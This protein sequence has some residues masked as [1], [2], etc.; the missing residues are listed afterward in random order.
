MLGETW[1]WEKQRAW[2]GG[3]LGLAPMRPLSPHGH[4]VGA[5]AAAPLLCRAGCCNQPELLP[6]EPRPGNALGTS[7]RGGS[8]FKTRLGPGHG[9]KVSGERAAPA[10]T[11]SAAKG[12]DRRTKRDPQ[13]GP[14][15]A[16]SPGRENR[17]LLPWGGT[18]N[19]DPCWDV[20]P[21]VGWKSPEP[22]GSSARVGLEWRGWRAWQGGLVGGWTPRRGIFPPD[23][24]TAMPEP[25]VGAAGGRRG[26]GESRKGN[27][28]GRSGAVDE[29]RLALL[30]SPCPSV[31]TISHYGS[32][33]MGMRSLS[34]KLS[35][36]VHGRA[37]MV[38]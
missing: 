11:A 10:P 30:A 31:V 17:R 14:G 35:P 20:R 2:D 1:G 23:A 28:G 12:G 32:L 21:Q 25:W 6:G 37:G 4:G 15:K 9:C 24:P 34:P 29:P 7:G 36:G 18:F 13:T 33:T 19:R 38:P 5:A 27:H 16:P 8:L 3:V 22:F 26:R